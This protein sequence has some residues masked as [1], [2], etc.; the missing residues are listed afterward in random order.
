M[1]PLKQLSAKESIDFISSIGNG[2]HHP[3][4]LYT[5]TLGVGTASKSGDFVQLNLLDVNPGSN[6]KQRK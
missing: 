2:H 5:Y 6:R 3:Y 1:L 4:N